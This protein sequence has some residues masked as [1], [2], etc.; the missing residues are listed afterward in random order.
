MTHLEAEAVEGIVIPEYVPPY[1][2]EERP[3]F[4]ATQV[5]DAKE[6]KT[7]KSYV[8]HT[9]GNCLLMGHHDPMGEARDYNAPLS[10]TLVRTDLVKSDKPLTSGD[11]DVDGRSIRI[12]YSTLKV[13]SGIPFKGYQEEDLY[14]FAAGLGTDTKNRWHKHNWL[15]D[16]TK[17]VIESKE[18]RIKVHPI[19]ALRSSL[20]W[21][22]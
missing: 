8:L 12:G 1:L 7:G 19:S 6:L 9:A 11:V 3:N 18:K 20:K 22:P 16:P 14:L 21:R 2:T 13:I 5:E 4:G 15:E 10:V 17:D